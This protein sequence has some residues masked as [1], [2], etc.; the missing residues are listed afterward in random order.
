MKRPSE[1]TSSVRIA[2][3]GIARLFRLVDRANSS[4]SAG[5]G[6]LRRSSIGEGPNC[7]KVNLFFRS[8]QPEFAMTENLLVDGSRNGRDD[9]EI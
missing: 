4:H 5:I 7:A 9:S 3:R 2:L 6:N 8:V 1:Q